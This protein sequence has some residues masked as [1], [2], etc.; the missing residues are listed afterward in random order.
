MSQ[1]ST[2]EKH[3]TLKHKVRSKQVLARKQ[4]LLRAIKENEGESVA[5]ISS[6]IIPLPM[7][8]CCCSGDRLGGIVV[9]IPGIKVFFS[10]VPHLL[11]LFLFLSPSKG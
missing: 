7:Y 5:R 8:A 6:F 10:S 2:Q 4:I 11:L 9:G 3:P 1:K